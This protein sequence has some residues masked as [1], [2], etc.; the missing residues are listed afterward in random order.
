MPSTVFTVSLFTLFI[1]PGM[2]TPSWDQVDDHKILAAV[3]LTTVFTVSLF[4]LFIG[5]GI[6]PPSW[7][8][9]MITRY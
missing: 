9:L 1:G 7:D 4:T 6:F 5:P 2:F 8:R 3:D